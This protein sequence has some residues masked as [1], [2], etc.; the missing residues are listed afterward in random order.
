MSRE[1]WDR[2]SPVA[3]YMENP[4]VLRLEGNPEQQ[5]TDDEVSRCSQTPAHP[6]KTD[7]ASY[8]S[9]ILILTTTRKFQFFCVNVSCKFGDLYEFCLFF[10][11]FS[12]SWCGW[13]EILWHCDSVPILTFSGSSFQRSKFH[14]LLLFFQEVFTLSSCLV[15]CVGITKHCY[16]R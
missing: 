11:C 15:S 10:F 7:D 16:C 5:E 1:N 8:I 12:F 14:Q 6:E 4:R 3:H 9:A 13:C 2:L